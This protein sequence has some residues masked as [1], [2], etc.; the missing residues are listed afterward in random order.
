VSMRDAKGPATSGD[1]AVASG[2]SSRTAGLVD[3]SAKVP[4]SVEE[5]RRH[6]LEAAIVRIMKARKMLNHIMIWLPRLRNNCLDVSFLRHNLSR[7]G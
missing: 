3:G 1:K 5:D 6:T 4:L 2:A 7:R